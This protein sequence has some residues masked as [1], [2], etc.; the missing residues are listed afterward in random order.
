MERNTWRIATKEIVEMMDRRRKE[1][2]RKSE[3]GGS[4]DLHR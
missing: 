1:G 2:E 3:I 4:N